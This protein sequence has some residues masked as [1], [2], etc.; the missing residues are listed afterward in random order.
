MY[1]TSVQYFQVCITQQHHVWAL[2]RWTAQL[3][4][5]WCASAPTHAR[6][7]PLRVRSGF[8]LVPCIPQFGIGLLAPGP[9]NHSRHPAFPLLQI[10][11]T[12]AWLPVLLALTRPEH[13]STWPRCDASVLEEPA[14]C[15]MFASVFVAVRFFSSLSDGGRN[16]VLPQPGGG[17]CAW[18]IYSIWEWLEP[19]VGNC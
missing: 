6:Q 1:T 5:A 13:R 11:P 8:T 19:G 14:V 9:P 3:P 2:R 12:L 15:L 10:G 18:A 4:S 7:Y 16:G 17:T